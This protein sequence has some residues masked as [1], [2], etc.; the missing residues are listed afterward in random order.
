LLFVAGVAVLLAGPV[1]A[2]VQQQSHLIY[3]CLS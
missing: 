2:N 1:N 3:S